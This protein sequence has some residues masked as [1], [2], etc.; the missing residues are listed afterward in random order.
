M[1]NPQLAGKVAV[2]TGANNP[3]GIG[4]ACAQALAAQGCAVLLHF[5][6]LPASLTHGAGAAY[7]ADHAGGAEAVLA[8]IH[9]RGGRAVA[10]EADLADPA[11]L[12]ALFDEAEARLGPVEI[13]INNA[14]HWQADTVRPD[15]PPPAGPAVWPPS[16]VTLSP[17]TIDPHFAVNTRA[18][19]LLMAEFARRHAARHA[20]WGRILNLSTDGADVFPSEASYAAS[21][22]ALESYSRTA[23]YELG[24]YGI[25]VNV[26]SPG[27]IQTDWITPELDAVIA[28]ASPLGRVGQPDDI[29]DVAV[30]LASH[31]ARW[32]TGQVIRV[33]GGNRM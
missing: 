12:P 9:A 19:A 4:A 14:A 23:A 3:H 18:V 17:E 11:N 6:R 26:I 22:A 10:W 28:A 31:Q 30:F 20:Q 32:I 2:V 33:G 5:W 27:P 16:A 7:Q 15:P 1:L 25:T 8:A 29:A 13:L 21:K 24:R